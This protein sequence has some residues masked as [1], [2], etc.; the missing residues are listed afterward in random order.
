M[1]SK[2]EIYGVIPVLHMPYLDDDSIDYDALGREIDH[3][4][5]AGADGITLALASE[6]LRLSKEE[7]YELTGRLPE[8]ANGRGTVTVSV[9][10]ETTR[11]AVRYAEA[12]EKSGA[13]AVMAVPPFTVSASPIEKFGYFKSIHDAIDIPLV[14]QDASGY[15]GGQSMSVDLMARMREELGPRIYY[16]PEALPT[17]PSITA[18][19]ERLRDEA[20]IFEGSGGFLL[21]D[22]YRRG[23]NGTMSGSDL[24]RAIIEVWNALERGDDDRAY[25]VYFPMSAIVMLEAPNLDTYLAIEKY[26]LVKQGVFKNTRVRRPAAYDLD[27]HTAAEIDRLYSRLESVL[28]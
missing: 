14:V 12:A 4:F 6:L 16:K 25:Q 8:M 18:L 9:G 26:L 15:M 24:I 27:P 17:G 1:K 21:I 22:S 5:D 2:P 23:V 19:R 3:V 28:S 7:R 20:V 11:E 13:T 10:A